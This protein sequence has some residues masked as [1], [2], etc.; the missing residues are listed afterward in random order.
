MIKIKSFVE[1]NEELQVFPISRSGTGKTKLNH[2]I[3]D[4][5]TSDKSLSAGIILNN[6]LKEEEFNNLANKDVQEINEINP[7]LAVA[8][9][10]L[11]FLKYKREKKGK[12]FCEYCGKGP[13]VIYDFINNDPKKKGKYRYNVR[14]NPKN[15]ATAD[16]KEPQSKGGD[17]FDYKN[18]AVCCYKCNQRKGDMPYEDWMELIKPKEK[19]LETF[20]DW[21]HIKQEIKDILQE[22]T[23]DGLYS[24]FQ[25]QD[26]FGEKRVLMYITRDITKSTKENYK[27]FCINYI[28]YA[29]DHL[30][31]YMD[32]VNL[33]IMRIRYRS[34]DGC[35]HGKDINFP[36]YGYFM[37]T[38]DYSDY[39]ISYD[40]KGAYNIKTGYMIPVLGPLPIE[41]I[42]KGVDEEILSSFELIFRIKY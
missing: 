11:N 27:K 21:S 36:Y 14:F 29:V 8:I 34:E 18:L 22:L 38:V 32:S 1:F 39:D 37:P 33:S 16:H 28:K 42:F 40:T 24:T 20:S 10:N 9:N 5:P 7:G 17:K 31:S 25:V 23:D 3:F 35:W 26:D 4:E 12:I 13:L 41:E 15:G 6:K 2:L 30:I 19:I